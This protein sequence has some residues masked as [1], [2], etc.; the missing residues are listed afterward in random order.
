MSKIL[1]PAKKIDRVKGR[2]RLF[3][4]ECPRCNSDAPAVDNCVVC[5]MIHVDGQNTMEKN[6]RQQFPPTVATKALWWYQW[7]NPGFK[8][9]QKS[10]RDCV[11]N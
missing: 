5:K 8:K 1:D 9:I 10:Y 2:I 4:G 6:V 7:V 11:G 3:F